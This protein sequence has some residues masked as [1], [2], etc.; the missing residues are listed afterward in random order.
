MALCRQLDWLEEHWEEADCGVWEVRG[1][2]QRFTYS[3][4]MTWVAF[5]RA[6][7]LARRR[8]LPRAAGRVARG[9]RPGLPADPG[10]RLEP[11]V[12][13]YVQYPAPRRWTPGP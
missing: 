5:E 7:R 10:A 13:A 9:G 6:G 3:T 11:R 1:P 4:L 8:G 12:G 2:E